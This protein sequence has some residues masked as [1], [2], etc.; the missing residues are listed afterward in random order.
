MRGVRASALGWL[1]RVRV[2]VGIHW[3]VRVVQVATATVKPEQE[4][5]LV[6]VGVEVRVEVEAPPTAD[7]SSRRARSCASTRSMRACIRHRS[8][9]PPP[10]HPLLP[11]PTSNTLGANSSSTNANG[12]KTHATATL[13][14]IRLSALLG[15]PASIAF[16]IVSAYVLDAPWLY[17]FFDR[18]TPVV[19]VGHGAGEG[20]G[21]SG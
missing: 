10:L 4:Q 2:A 6:G 9:A 15:P 1:I 12:E 5:A 17:G 16:A 3:A 11:L 7:G 14:C 13:E 18:A 19:V 20:G 8:P 21:E